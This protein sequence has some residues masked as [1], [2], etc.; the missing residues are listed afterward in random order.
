MATIVDTVNRAL[1]HLG[2]KAN[3]A[4]IDPPD[5]SVEANWAARFYPIAVYRTLEMADWSFAR[6]RAPLASV[7]LPLGTTWL[8]A[9]QIPSD[10]LKP[11]RLITGNFGQFEDDSEPFSREGETLLTN[12]AE[13]ILIYTQPITD[14]TKFPPSFIET[15]AMSLAADLAGPILKGNEGVQASQ[16]LRE[17]AEG[18]AMRAAADDGDA[19]D[20]PQDQYQPA[21]LR[22]RGRGKYDRSATGYDGA[23]AS[24][25]EVI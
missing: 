20:R 13:A 22:A 17:A 6:K 23:P 1:A 19:Q 18:Y 16:R 9:Y 7:D 5:G 12:K 25:F 8:Y 21:A 2:N 3:V 10:C 14:A 15:L 11:R 24:G 4:S